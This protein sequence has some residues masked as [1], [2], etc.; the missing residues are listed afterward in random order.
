MAP[1]SM[2]GLTKRAPKSGSSPARQRRTSAGKLPAADEKAQ[3]A[4]L[5]QFID[6]LEVRLRELDAGMTIVM[7]RLKG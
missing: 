6:G 3:A 2:P 5:S 1:R 7:K 4:E